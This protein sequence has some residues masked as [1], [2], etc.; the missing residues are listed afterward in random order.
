PAP[1]RTQRPAAPEPGS[2]GKLELPDAIA[3]KDLAGKIGVQAAAIVKYLFNQGIMVT[4][5]QSVDFETAAKVATKLGYE[6]VRP[7][8]PIA[9]AWTDQEDPPEKLQPIPPV[10]T[11][12]G[13]VDHGKTTLLDAIRETR[14]AASEAGGIT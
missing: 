10:V 14:V 12:M 13:H 3:V 4:V 7:K 11:I 1:Q 6:V 2:R 9:E 5:N 8:D